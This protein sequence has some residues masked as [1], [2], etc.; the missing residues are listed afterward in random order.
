[1]ARLLL[2]TWDGA[3]NRVPL[4]ALTEG[5]IGRGHE[6]AVRSHASTR[7]HYERLG[8][9]FAAHPTAADYDA[10]ARFGSDERQHAAWVFEHVFLSRDLATDAGRAV[11][12]ARPDA[13]IVDD[14]LLLVHA[15]VEAT[16]A[17]ALSFAHV[18]S[19]SARAR[20]RRNRA[21]GFA[22]DTINEHRKDL[23]LRP[24]PSVV[25]AAQ[26]SRRTVAATAPTFD[27]PDVESPIVQV[28]PIRPA[29]RIGSLRPAP[30]RPLVVVGLSSGWMHQVG[31]LQRIL[32]ALADMD[33]DVRLGLGS[34]SASELD[35]PPN[36]TLVEH[37]PHDAIL[38]SAALLITH[39]GHGTVMAGLSHGV[40]MLCVPLGRD[41]PANAARAAELGAAIVLE[42][43]A[44]ATDLRDAALRLLT[45]PTIR[46]RCQ[47]LAAAVR[48]ETSVDRALAA[49]EGLL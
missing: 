31:L 47:R 19:A 12:D 22:L 37:I 45:D 8:A 33:V 7:E 18:P 1:M 5:L 6:V 13:V 27:P 29:A 30:T 48:A 39:A 49:V 41:Q 36:A 26:V 38:P 11:E 32:D 34:V 9:S 16:G 15:A 3:G 21:F 43:D 25:A 28:G 40:P 2:L 4:L 46:S 14:S 35:P 20:E 24:V 44:A 42:P 10:H 23:G 17:P